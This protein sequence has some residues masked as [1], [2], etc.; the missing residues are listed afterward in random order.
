MTKQR[1][2]YKYRPQ[3]EYPNGL[4][5]HK[6]FIRKVERFNKI[7]FLRLLGKLLRVKPIERSIPLEDV[8]SVLIIR[9]DALGDMI[10]TTPLWRILKR[11]KPEIKIGVAGSFKNLDLLRADTDID[12]LYD[13]T[14]SSLR[15][16]IKISKKTRK[17]QCDVVLMGNF[18]QKTRNSIIARLASPRG[19]TATVGSPNKEGHQK[20]FSRLVQLPLP[21]NEMPMTSQLQFLLK[22]VI[23]LPPTEDERPSIMIDTRIESDTRS[24]IDTILKETECLQYIVLNID[25]PAFKK[26]SLENN[27]FLAKFISAQYP[28]FAI[29]LTSLPENK[30]TIADIIRNES[31]ARAR[32]FPTPDIHA[33]TTLIRN[34]QL[35]ITPDTSIVHLASAESKPVVAF[36]LAASEWLPY[37]INSYV[38]LPKKGEPI[39]TIPFDVVKEGVIAMLSNKYIPDAYTTY[40]VHC[41][42][43]SKIEA[44]K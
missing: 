22:A 24:N 8:S 1:Q 18:N 39:K 4:P 36:Y 29:M 38:I 35:V 11:L 43:P 40:I 23:S 37:K 10:V 14:A 32:Y 25:A 12:F 33:M 15:D 19:I 26:W 30:D 7:A 2:H 31:I 5:W 27:I 28:Q 13:Y 17:Q 34:S 44:R 3:K 20:L 6:E 21:M 9:Y 42:E 41:D 16:F